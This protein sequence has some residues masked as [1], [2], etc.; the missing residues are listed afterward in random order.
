MQVKRISADS[1]SPSLYQPSAPRPLSFVEFIWQADILRVILVA[2]ASCKKHNHQLGHMLFAGSS[3]YGKTTLAHLIAQ[4][5]WSG[6]KTITAYALSKPSDLLS[7]LHSLQPGDVLFID[8]IHR[9][10]PLLEEM[11][12]IAMED[13]AV[14]MIMPDGD[15]LRLP[16]PHFTLIGATT[17]PEALAAPLKNRFVYPFHLHEYS[18]EEQ[19]QLLLRYLTINHISVPHELM[20]QLTQH[21]TCVPR[22]IANF[23]IILR[24][25]LLVHTPDSMPDH[26]DLSAAQW[27]SF[28]KRSSIQKWGLTPLHQRYIALLMSANGKPVGLKTLAYQLSVNEETIEQ[29]I[30]PL[31]FKL[32]KIEKTPKWRLLLDA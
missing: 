24:D 9:L 3:G 31:L 18:A 11:L 30:E 23:C 2:L 15:H 16:L 4:E 28:L 26:L 27:T 7:L 22:E 14:D 19:H 29:D 8:E 10:K 32:G 1:T 5:L 12:Y 21:I 20:S 25:Y 17:R 13:Y 6:I